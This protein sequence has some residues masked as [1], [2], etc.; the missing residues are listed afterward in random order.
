MQKNNY[1]NKQMEENDFKIKRIKN[2][3][4][5]LSIADLKSIIDYANNKKQFGDFAQWNKVSSMASERLEEKIAY[6]FEFDQQ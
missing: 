6:M 5:E 3:L 4:S 2:Q 1:N